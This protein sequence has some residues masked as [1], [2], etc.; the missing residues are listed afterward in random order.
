MKKVNE[1][2][3]TAAV[4]EFIRQIRNGNHKPSMR[5]ILRKQGV[6]STPRSKSLVERMIANGIIKKYSD[7]TYHLAQMNYESKEIMPILLKREYH[8]R[9]TVSITNPLEGFSSKQLVEE[10]RNRGYEVKA[11]KLVEESL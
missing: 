4:G 6:D 10:L 11:T 5:M 7:G 9:I 2:A 1:A 3:C 8:R